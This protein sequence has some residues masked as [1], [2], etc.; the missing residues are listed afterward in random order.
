MKYDFSALSNVGLVRDKNEDAVVLN[1]PRGVAVLADGMGGHNAGEV[2]STLAAQL[3]ASEL[4]HWLETCEAVNVEDVRRAVE[5]SVSHANRAI[6]EAA[7]THPGYAGMG[8]TV[9]LL[10]TCD[11]GLVIGHVGDSRAYRWRGS[12]LTQ[13]TRDHSL[14][15]QQIDA[16][17][18]TP[19]QAAISAQRNVVTRALGVEETVRLDAQALL[20]HVGDIYLLCTDGLSDLVSEAEI[21]A[22]L[23]RAGSLNAKATQ[24]IGLANSHGGHDNVSV[25]LARVKAAR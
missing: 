12:E 18:I 15:Q 6:F 4:G 22:A 1:A 11:N 21:A 20:A 10:V 19:Q 2:A 24:L 13:I 14:L 8:T 9:V 16:G 3:I 7:R 5:I 23:G 25:V 17:Q